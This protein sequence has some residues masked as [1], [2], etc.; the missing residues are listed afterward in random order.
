MSWIY[1]LSL[2]TYRG[3]YVTQLEKANSGARN[4]Q[5]GS[6]LLQQVI[7]PAPLPG[8]VGVDEPGVLPILIHQVAMVTLLRDPAICHHHNGVTVLEILKIYRHDFLFIALYCYL[9]MSKKKKIC[10]KKLCLTFRTK[11]P[12]IYCQEEINLYCIIKLAT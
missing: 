10:G 2:R 3:M 8:V 11:T 5:F 9:R 12:N 4:S 1:L 6:F 7:C